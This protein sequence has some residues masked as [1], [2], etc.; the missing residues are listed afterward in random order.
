MS[1]LWRDVAMRWLREP[2][3][4]LAAD[5]ASRWRQA[6]ELR[7][8]DDHLLRDIGLL[9]REGRIDRPARLLGAASWPLPAPPHG[10]DRTGFGPAAG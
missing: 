6:E 2:V 4:Y 5:P 1:G 8:L 7:A 3:L 10:R 9:G